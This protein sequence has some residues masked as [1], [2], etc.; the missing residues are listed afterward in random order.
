MRKNEGLRGRFTTDVV[1]PPMDPPRMDEL[2]RK[3]LWKEEIEVRDAPDTPCKRAKT[4]GLFGQLSATPGWSN[5]R[6]IQTLAGMIT[7]SVYEFATPE[8]LYGKDKECL[9]KV[10]TAEVNG[11]LEGMLQERTQAGEV[12]RGQVSNS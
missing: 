7:G 12:E 10:S 2:L 6:D 5:G 11:F 8:G 9:L 3:R 4:L 1:F